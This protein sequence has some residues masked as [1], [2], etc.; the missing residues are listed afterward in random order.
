MS[1]MADEPAPATVDPLR[2]I[3]TLAALAVLL[4]FVVQGLVLAAKLSFGGTTGAAAFAVDLAA[5]VAWSAVVCLG[6][7]IGV[8]AFRAK[9]AL[10]GLVAAL[11]A[12]LGVAAAK[13][14]NQTLSAAIGLSAKPAA[15][16]L[17]ALAGLKAVEYA[18]LGFVLATLVQ[19]GVQRLPPYA[20]TGLT[21][22]LVF[23]GAAL[24]LRLAAA[25]A[26]APE[27]AA[28]AVNE[29]VFPVGCAA[30]VYLGQ[31]MGRAG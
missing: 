24:A 11:F 7:S 20:A 15:L 16:P 27:I 8:S 29:I 6:A 9:A 12:P 21:V 5:G 14:A 3:G 31:A 18:V 26:T 13:A 1:L 22:G 4:G 28:L 2:R 25:L 23:G 17:I 19:R 30:V 10:A